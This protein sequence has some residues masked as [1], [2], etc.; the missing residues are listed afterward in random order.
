MGGAA[1]GG[2]GVAGI[3]NVTAFA[4]VEEGE[5]VE[6]MSQGKKQKREPRAKS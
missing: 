6:G 1:A 3:G 4:A 2:G 5:G